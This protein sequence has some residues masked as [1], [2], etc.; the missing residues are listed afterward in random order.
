MAADQPLEGFVILVVEDDVDTL[1][2]IENLIC[3]ALGCDVLL[4]SNGVEALQ[5]IDSGAH[6]DLVFSDIMMPMMGGLTLTD[7]LRKRLPTVPVVLATGLTAVVDA[8]IER[9][10]IALLKPFTLQQLSS[11]LCEQLL[12]G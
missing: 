11:V 5:I 4:A 3:R 8:A 7:E 6:V 12:Y 1:H 9:G 2:A 10:A